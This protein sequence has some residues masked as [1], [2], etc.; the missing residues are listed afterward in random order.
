MKNLDL[1]S[2][3]IVQVQFNGLKTSNPMFQIK[4][5]TSSLPFFNMLQFGF[6]KL[7]FRVILNH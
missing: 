6:F 7:S 4:I 2:L 3:F 1:V 5:S